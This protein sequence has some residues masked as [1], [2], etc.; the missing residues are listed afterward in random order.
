MSEDQK[1]LTLK[2]RKWLKLYIELGNA[3]EA[4]WQVYDCKDRESAAQIGWENIRK[5]D[6][7]ELMEESGLTDKYLNDKL[8]EGLEAN[9]QMGARIVIKK[10]TPT[11]QAD[12][13]LMPATSQTDDFIEVEDYAVRHKYLET[14]LKL[15]GRLVNKTDITSDG[16][17]IFD[18]GAVLNKVYGDEPT[19]PT[20]MPD[21]SS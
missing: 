1:K 4:A 8:K 9:K 10:N 18:V 15:N 11:S 14:A 16:E 7:A 12:G 21:D 3:S 20:E 2:Q 13:E 19:S 6:V 17:R 5:L